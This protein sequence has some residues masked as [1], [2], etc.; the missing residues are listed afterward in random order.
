MIDAR[1]LTRTFAFWETTSSRG[2]PAERDLPCPVFFAVPG[3]TIDYDCKLKIH[4]WL[5][6][7]IL[8]FRL[9]GVHTRRRPSGHYTAGTR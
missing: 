8:S 3:R 9:F 4:F 1:T 6:Y 5:V 7:F 2:W